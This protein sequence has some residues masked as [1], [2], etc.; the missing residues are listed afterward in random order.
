VRLI[1]ATH[2]PLPRLAESDRFRRDLYFRI[3]GITLTLPPLRERPRDLPLLVALEVDRAARAQRKAIVGLSRSA[4][5]RLFA[6]TWPGNLR[7]LNR[8]IHTA[9]ALAAADTIDREAVLLDAPH[10]DSPAAREAAACSAGPG[11]NDILTLAEIERH[12]IERVLDRFGGNKRR[13][14]QALNV[15]RSTLDRKLAIRGAM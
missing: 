7:E 6:H 9:V 3:S 10:A 12:Y 4:A 2:L 14:A 8:V 5:D 11:G 15:S 13:T 1:S